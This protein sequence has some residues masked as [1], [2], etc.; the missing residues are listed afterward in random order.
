M[1]RGDD[2]RMPRRGEA[3][4]V[5][6]SRLEICS[7]SPMTGFLRNGCCHTMPQD[8]G[9]HTVCV[10]MTD[11]F[12]AY[13]KAQGND[14]STPMPD[15]GFSGLKE[16]DRW[17]LCAPRWQEAFLADKAPKVVLRATHEEALRHCSLKDL[18]RFAVDQ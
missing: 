4:N 5:L 2:D 18:T 12:L 7:I 11:E 15:Y 14:L 6:G 16:G 8:V 9:S 13:S 3:R 1:P 10:V 17:C